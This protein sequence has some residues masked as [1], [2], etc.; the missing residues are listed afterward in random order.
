[1][2]V[3]L[4]G[5]RATTATSLT[6]YA[7]GGTAPGTSDV[8]LNAGEPTA[9]NLAIVP[10]GGDGAIAVRNRAGAVDV[11]VDVLGYHR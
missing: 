9:S 10:L 3:S 4:T 6:A 7:A 8:S 1:V 5:A 2:V 11:A